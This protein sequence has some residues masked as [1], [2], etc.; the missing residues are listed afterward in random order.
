ML[1]WSIRARGAGHY[2]A[3]A[4]VVLVW[5]LF[6]RCLDLRSGEQVASG[7]AVHWCTCCSHS[8]VILVN[9]GDLTIH[10][11]SASQSHDSLA[12]ETT[13]RIPVPEVTTTHGW[14]TVVSND[15]ESTILTGQKLANVLS[16]KYPVLV[17]H[18][19]LF[20]LWTS[21]GCFIALDQTIL[22]LSHPLL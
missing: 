20:T 8:Y 15:R 9:T 18:I 10:S 7:H 2:Q 16:R 14:S 6:V 5:C 4:A 1:W 21:T 13:L 3:G 11:Q 19:N 22:G 17:L 12:S